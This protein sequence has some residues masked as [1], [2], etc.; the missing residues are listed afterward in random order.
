MLLT[1]AGYYADLLVYPPLV[2]A[3]IGGQLWAPHTAFHL[4][5][6]VAFVIGVSGWTLVEY[7]VHRV[8]LHAV[9]VLM[10][11]HDMHHKN[12]GAYVGTPTWISLAAFAAG[13]FAPVWWLSG[14]EVASGS[15]AG[16]MLGYCWYLTVHVAVHRWRLEPGAPL[17]AAKLRHACHHCGSPE[18]NF[19]VTI[20]LWDRI[21]GTEVGRTAPRMRSMR[22]TG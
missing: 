20:A 19:G 9:P 13:A 7:A 14:F 8:A 4:H 5:G 2:L 10:T 22:N 1:K 12:P 6:I 11:M 3:L 21:L 16:L 17:Y 15:T 18:G